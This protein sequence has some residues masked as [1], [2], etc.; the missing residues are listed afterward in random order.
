MV[1][2]AMCMKSCQ[3]SNDDVSDTNVEKL[4]KCLE[5]CYVT[6]GPHLYSTL[7]QTRTQ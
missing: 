5:T 2:H 7:P 1:N 3:D 4:E 6:Y